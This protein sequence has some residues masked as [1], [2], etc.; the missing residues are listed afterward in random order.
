MMQAL[1]M[2]SQLRPVTCCVRCAG[3]AAARAPCSEQGG[4]DSALRSRTDLGG[5]QHLPGRASAGSISGQLWWR[6]RC[7][8]ERCQAANVQ[9]L[10]PSYCATGLWSSQTTRLLPMVILAGV[11]TSRDTFSGAECSIANAQ[12]GAGHMTPVLGMVETELLAGGRHTVS[13][14]QV[15]CHQRLSC[16]WPQ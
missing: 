2:Q 6:F 10:K 15:Q 7:G 13:G 11:Q 14:G 4:S 5:V 8:A 16:S 3:V 1:Q 12:A 9:S